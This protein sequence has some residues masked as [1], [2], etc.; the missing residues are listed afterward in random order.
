MRVAATG[1]ERRTAWPLA[2][3]SLALAL[4]VLWA[5]S[6]PPGDGRPGAGLGAVLDA[7]YPP[8]PAVLGAAAGAMLETLRIA[9]LGSLAGLLAGAVLAPLAAASAAPRLLRL[10]VSGALALAAAVPPLLPALVLVAALGAGPL[11]GI[12][13]LGVQGGAALALG[14]AAALD[15]IDPA[16]VAA[17]ARA[18]AGPVQRLRFG[19]W[20]Q[21]APA[22]ARETLARFDLNLREAL[23]IGV[24]GAGGIGTL[25]RDVLAQG[26]MARFGTVALVLLATFLPVALANARLCRALAR[27]AP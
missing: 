25:V 15:R 14:Y 24:V 27:E 21:A 17:L 10:P 12:L 3:P 4:V 11:P 19:A 6:A 9:L 5:A 23:V 26:D 13:A 1:A 7:M 18:G 16:P 2:L 22:L 8:D 20:P